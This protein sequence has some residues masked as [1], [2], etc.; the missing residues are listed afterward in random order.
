MLHI[1]IVHRTSR[2]RTENARAAARPDDEEFL[3]SYD[4]TMYP[5]PSVAV[6][7]VLLTVKDGALWT[8]LGRRPHPPMQGRWAL[9]GGFVGLAESIDA[10]AA[11]VLAA[12]AGLHDV[13]IEQLYTFGDP[14]R[15]PRTRVVS[16]AYFALV[17]A[18]R[19]EAAVAPAGSDLRVARVRVPWAGESGGPVAAVDD[20]GHLLGLAFDHGTILGAAVRRLRGKVEYAPLG[21]ELLPERFTLRELR[22]V[23]E[24]ILDRPL[25]KDSFRRR[26]IDAGLVAATGQRARGVGHRPAELFRFAEA[27]AR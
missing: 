19:L 1:C 27:A 6:D 12:K 10:A 8:L 23:H 17:D 14:D 15:D 4:P 18:A 22:L 7:V 16:V 21:F 11:R 5:R 3:A 24:A 26:V 20:D 9:P 25:N 2:A 13:F